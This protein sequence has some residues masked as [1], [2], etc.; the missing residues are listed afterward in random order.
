MFQSANGG[1]RAEPAC[2]GHGHRGPRVGCCRSREL[3][4]PGVLADRCFQQRHQYCRP[5]RTNPHPIW[6]GQGLRVRRAGAVVSHPAGPDASAAA[7]R[8]GD[9]CPWRVEEYG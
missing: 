1:P 5:A 6:P 7:T 8:L 4:I 9:G 3:R 2:C